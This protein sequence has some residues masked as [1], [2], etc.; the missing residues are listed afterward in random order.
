MFYTT[1]WADFFKPEISGLSLTRKNR[2]AE[3]WNSLC[4]S[5]VQRPDRRKTWSGVS[6]ENLRKI[7]L[8]SSPKSWPD[9]EKAFTELRSFR[10]RILDPFPWIRRRCCNG[11]F[12]TEEISPSLSDRTNG[13]ETK[14][15]L[16]YFRNFFP[17]E[18][19]IIRPFRE[20]CL[21]NPSEKYF[22]LCLLR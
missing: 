13:R 21:R 3:H 9:R 1:K 6:S 15:W 11:S 2:F 19:L 18:K 8:D 4:C 12:C 16:K 14:I 22:R 7:C 10:R 20:S 17:T 5:D